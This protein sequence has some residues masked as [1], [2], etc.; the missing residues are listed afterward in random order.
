MNYENMTI[1]ELEARN[2]EL[3][4]QRDAIREEQLKIKAVLD[5]KIALRSAQQ[6]LA[7]LSETE[8]AALSLVISKAG[9][10]ESREQVGR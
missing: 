9:G 2:R 5:R 3:N 7:S 1:E 8:R 6:K 10:I 4:A